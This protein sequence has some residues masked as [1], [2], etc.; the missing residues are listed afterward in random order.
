MWLRM[1][2]AA[3]E[4][5]SAVSLA[6]METGMALY[7]LW[8]LTSWSSCTSPSPCRLADC[9]SSW[10]RSVGV[11]G[12][13]WPQA[14][15]WWRD[16]IPEHVQGARVLARDGA[17]HGAL[18]CHLQQL[19]PRHAAPRVALACDWADDSSMPM[20]LVCW[21]TKVSEMKSKHQDELPWISLP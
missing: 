15:G 9:Y 5:A 7:L 21:T 13:L 6:S 12:G 19:Q 8:P 14:E 10:C 17:C 2:M 4:A 11:C 16:N 1:K 18:A 3:S 20:R